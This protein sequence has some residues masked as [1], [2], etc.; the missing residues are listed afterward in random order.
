MYPIYFIL[1]LYATASCWFFGDNNTAG[2]YTIYTGAMLGL[3][4]SVSS[5]ACVQSVDCNSLL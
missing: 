3:N 5:K 1:P 4:A 2:H